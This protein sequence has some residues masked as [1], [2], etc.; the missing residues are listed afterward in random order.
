MRGKTMKTSPG[1]QDG[2]RALTLGTFIA[3]EKK[4]FLLFRVF[5]ITLRL[6]NNNLK[7]FLAIVI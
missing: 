7:L 5:N 1:Y 4:W 6:M 3:N 2:K